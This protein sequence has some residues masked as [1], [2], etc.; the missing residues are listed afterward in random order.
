L[1]ARMRLASRPKWRMR[2]K[3]SGTTWRRK[4]GTPRHGA[5]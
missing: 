3:P 4:R 1:A 5:P 2:T